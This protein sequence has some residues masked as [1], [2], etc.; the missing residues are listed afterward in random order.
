MASSCGIRYYIYGVKRIWTI[1]GGVSGW[2]LGGPI[3]AI[4]GAGLGELLSGSSFD[5]HERAQD[6]F[7]GGRRVRGKDHTQPGDFHISLLILSAVVIKS[8]GV[9]DQRELDY[10]RSRFVALFGQDKANESFKIFKELVAKDIKVR[11]V[12]EQIRRNMAHSGRLQL[13]HFLFGVASADGHTDD[14][15]LETIKRIARYLY[16]SDA[17]FESI[18]ATF[19]PKST[20]ENH[21]KILHIT[22]S[23]SNEEV[24]KAYRKMVVKYHPD[25]VQHLGD[26]VVNAAKE[27]FLKVQEAYDAICKSRGI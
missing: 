1:L 7:S 22:A 11:A 23:A 20:L 18:Q 8:D 12:A 13:V 14:R 16:V 27:K 26:D 15:E 9:V 5:A 2:I 6:T 25:K 3:G 19:T 10:V 21:Y 17:D 4:V 24:K